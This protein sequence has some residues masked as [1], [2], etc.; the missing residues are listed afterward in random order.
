MES[1][2]P[3]S[4]RVA[5]IAARLGF[6][7]LGC[8]RLSGGASQETWLMSATRDGLRDDLILRRS[9]NG[10]DKLRET[11]AG[12]TAE[13]ALMRRAARSAI[14][15]PD[16][17]HVLTA[18]DE[19]GAG[20]ISRRVFGETIP[21]KILRE[22]AY[23]AARPLLAAQSGAIL[24]AIHA[25]PLDELPPLQ[26][27]TAAQR[28]EAL[29]ARYD[30][31]GERRPIFELAFR[32]LGERTPVD[33]VRRLCHGDFRNGNLIIDA[34]GIAAVLDWELA[35]TGDPIED[36]GWLC[37]PSWRFGHLNREAGGFGTR[38]DLLDAYVAAGGP[39]V[40]PRRIDFWILFG[41]LAWGI[42]CLNFAAEFRTGDR[43]VE[44][45]SIGRR[46]SETELDLMMLL[47]GRLQ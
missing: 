38:D 30:R 44:R 6:V 34:D 37:V 7:M 5:E 29:R 18:A 9:P 26:E 33:A 8:D 32:W 43:T 3:F 31:I 40:D 22:D 35:H 45:A 41:T 39:A 1:E 15:V 25:I 13:A 36:L 27:Q 12:L 24:A 16:V 21:K 17:V 10:Q 47:T 14:P 23:R 4:E 46:V 20:F 2:K 19:L 28:V 42:G 11:S